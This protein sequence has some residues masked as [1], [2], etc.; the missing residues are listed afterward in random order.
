M[1][2]FRPEEKEEE[3][4]AQLNIESRE[5]KEEKRDFAE[6]QNDE[7]NQDFFLIIPTYYF[8]CSK[9]SFKIIAVRQKY[10]SSKE[11]QQGFQIS[12]YFFPNYCCQI[13]DRGKKS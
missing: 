4:K 5:T 6:K 10:L 9:K 12:I 3:E 13:R 1:R 2:I 8:T 7:G 11:L